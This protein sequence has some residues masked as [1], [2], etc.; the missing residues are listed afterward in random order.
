[1][2][3]GEVFATVK[4]VYEFTISKSEENKDIIKIDLDEYSE[5]ALYICKVNYD[6]SEYDSVTLKRDKDGKFSKDNYYF[7]KF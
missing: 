6:K 1:M 5:G 4:A 7:E 3:F 2:K